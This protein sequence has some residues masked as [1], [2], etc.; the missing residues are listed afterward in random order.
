MDGVYLDRPG[1]AAFDLAAIEQVEI[2]RGPQGTLF[3]KNTTAGAVTFVTRSPDFTHGADGN[4][5][6]G[7]N[8]FR[9][10]QLSVTGPLSDSLA[11]RLT[12]YTTD[13][14][15]YLKNRYT[16]EDFLSLHRQGLRG[17]ILFR[18]NADVSWRLIGE[19]GRQQDSSGAMLLYSK[20]PAAGASPTFLPYDTWARNLG[21]TPPFDPDGLVTE[22][23]SLQRPTERQVAATSLL[24]M[25]FDGISLDAVT[26]WRSWQYLP[27]FDSDFSR[28]DVI[29]D[30]GA[31]NRQTQFSH[32][33]RLSGARPELDLEYLVGAYLFTRQMRTDTYLQ[34]GAQ[35]STGL[36]ALGNPAFNN[37]G[38]H[39][40][41]DVSSATYALFLQTSWRLAPLWNLTVG[42]RESYETASGAIRRIAPS[43]GNGPTPPN[44]APYQGSLETA[45]WTP[46]ALLS[47]DHRLGA[48]TM[49]Y[50]SLSY[51][52]KS[53]GFNPV[54][55]ASQGGAPQPIST[56]K[57]LPEEIVNL[58]WGVKTA[59]P[60]YDLVLDA[61]AYWGD[62]NGY[63]ANAAMVLSSG[64]L[65]TLITNA[66]S[67]RIQGFEAEASYAPLPNLLV[68]A[69]LGYNDAHYLS[70]PNAPAV[71][72][73]ASP[74]QDLSHRPLTRAP[75]WTFNAAGSYSHTV[76][77][78]FDLFVRGEVSLQSGSYGYIDDSTYA[79]FNG[80]VT[81]DLSIGA[82]IRE[83]EAAF[84]VDNVSDTRSFTGMFPA[85]T[86]SAGYFAA[87]GLPRLW[88]V[89]LRSSLGG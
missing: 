75:Q 71:Q 41:S 21:L 55:P 82:Q 53:G 57:V 25:E 51:G 74:T 46:A 3:G 63:Q 87:P 62:V 65:Q 36:G 50:G 49:V 40:Y 17:Q 24:S 72:G 35:F 19:Y 15:G 2:L 1:M 73:S 59:L 39:T 9:Q 5:T 18:P 33:M 34:Y 31:S 52:A 78:G 26:G 56:L 13:R 45:E 67:T 20:G 23:D 10:L 84:W 64:G 6:L 76:S 30:L 68:H 61:N 16:G 85:S 54:V 58:E 29:R 79:R 38:S 42:V 37:L 60:D 80:A 32:E 8:N 70:F 14:D 27:H 88:G 77:T 44:L 69:A 4:V 12:A 48:A 66:G 28:A 47:L 43:G 7:A 83:L 86:G 81:G 11:F 22:A 89:T